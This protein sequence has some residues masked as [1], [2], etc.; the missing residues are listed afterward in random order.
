MEPTPSQHPAGKS[1]VALQEMKEN[2]DESSPPA[3]RRK[4]EAKK[5]L[6]T[7][8]VDKRVVDRKRKGKPARSR[9]ATLAEQ[10][11]ALPDCVSYWR[12]YQKKSKDLTEEEISMF[13]ENKGHAK[14]VG[15]GES[16]LLIKA[17]QGLG[18]WKE[19]NGLDLM[20]RSYLLVFDSTSDPN[21][22][23]IKKEE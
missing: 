11:Y 14:K 4:T 16:T 12:F 9:F 17:R 22:S 19:M 21:E 18:G 13:E 8:E 20:R 1:P 3:K 15:G 5:N 2:H 6:P 23:S 7:V 10:S